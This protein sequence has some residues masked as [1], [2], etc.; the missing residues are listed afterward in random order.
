MSPARK[1]PT[2]PNTPGYSATSAYLSDVR[3]VQDQMTS[4]EIGGGGGLQFGGEGVVPRVLSREGESGGGGLAA[5]DLVVDL[6]PVDGHGR[7]GHDAQ[8]APVALQRHNDD[9]NVAVDD[10][11]FPDLSR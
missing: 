8:P 1:K 2:W 9:L 3:E 5:P 4:A 10:D 11:A 6:L 7:W